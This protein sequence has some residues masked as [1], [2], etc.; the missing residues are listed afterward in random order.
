MASY[1]YHFILKIANF[2]YSSHINYFHTEECCQCD[3]GGI[4]VSIFG[5]CS[6]LQKE[7]P[8]I[9]GDIRGKPWADLLPT[10]EK[11]CKVHQLNC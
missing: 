3:L 9:T 2:E 11:Q 6:R 4:A 8:A 1:T 7:A 5:S 10:H